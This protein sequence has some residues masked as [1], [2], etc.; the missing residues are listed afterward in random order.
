MGDVNDIPENELLGRVLRHLESHGRS[1]V[2]VPLWSIVG[3]HFSLGSG[4]SMQ[5]CRKYG[6]DPDKMV[7]R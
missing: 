2:K 5:L 1:R 6:I 4:Y 7:K 3:D